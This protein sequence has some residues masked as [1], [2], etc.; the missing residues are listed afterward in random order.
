MSQVNQNAPKTPAAPQPKQTNKL[1]SALPPLGYIGLAGIFIISMWMAFQSSRKAARRMACSNN[2]K[3]ISLAMHNYHDVYKQFP[4]AYTLDAN[5]NKLHSWRTLLLPYVGKE[6]L[7]GKIDLSKPW[8][9]PVNKHL[10]DTIVPVY[11]CPS[12]PGGPTP[13]TPYQVVLD[14]AAIFTGE[15]SCS[16]KSIP[17]DSSNTVL[18]VE[19]KKAVPWMSPVDTDLATF[20]SNAK[21]D[22]DGGQY[23]GMADG[24]IHF[25][26]SS[27]PEPIRKA[28]VT[29]AGGESDHE[30]RLQERKKTSA[31]HTP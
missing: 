5:G 13:N 16:Y 26:S 3:M 22:H 31:Q 15:S 23:V 8:D 29:I 1:L 9:D 18:V 6:A 30:F 7:Y 28:L 10:S 11:A 14:P 20:V 19:T 27:T 12:A 4:P 17:D 2:F 25:I 21:S 24:S